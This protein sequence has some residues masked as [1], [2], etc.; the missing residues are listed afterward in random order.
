M[1]RRVAGDKLTVLDSGCCGMAG[2]FGYGEKRFDLSMQIGELVLFPAARGMTAK[3]VLVAPGTSC[4][5][6]VHDGVE[7][8]AVHPMV[9]LAGSLA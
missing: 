2:S 7:K 3:D 9:Y 8:K 6:Q 5:H 4:R 1:L